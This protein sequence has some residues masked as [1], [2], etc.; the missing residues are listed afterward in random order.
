[1]IGNGKIRALNPPV[2]RINAA[3][4]IYNT[5]NN[6]IGS[7]TNRD[8]L[9]SFTIERVG[10]ESSFFG[11]GICQKLNVHL[12]SLDYKPTTDYYI[13][14]TVWDTENYS[15]IYPRFNI[16]EV[17]KNENNS[18]LSVTAYDAIYNAAEHTIE[19]L[20]TSV[21]SIREFAEVIASFLG[22]GGVELINITDSCFDTVY[23]ETALA[24]YEGTETLREV[25]DDIA[26]ATQTIYYVNYNNRLVFKRLDKDGAAALTIGKE[27]YITLD[28]GENRRLTKIVSAT[29]LGDDIEATLKGA[30]SG[31]LIRVDDVAENTHIVE[32]NTSAD[33]VFRYGKNIA[34]TI[35]AGK[36]IEINGMTFTGASDGAILVSGIP[37]AIAFVE[38]SAITAPTKEGFLTISLTGEFNNVVT[39]FKIKDKDGNL[40]KQVQTANRETINLSDYP[41]ATEWIVALKR[42]NNNVEASGAVYYQVEIGQSAT[43]YEKYKG[44]AF[45]ADNTGAFNVTSTAPTMT[46]CTNSAASELNIVYER[47]NTISGTT[48]YIRN[49]ALWDL[50]ED[51][52]SLIDKALAQVWGL[53]INQFECEWRGNYLL[54]IGDKIDL[55]AKDNN[56]VTS[57]V[58][59]DVI[60]YSGGFK[61]RTKWHYTESEETAANASNIG[62][63]LKQTYA[64]VDK[65]NKQIDIVA[66]QVDNNEKSIAQIYIDTESIR[67]SAKSTKEE[68]VNSIDNINANINTINTKVEAAITAEDVQLKIEQELSN[69]VDKVKTS[70][71]YTFNDDGLIVEKSD[72]EMK[73]TIS[74]DGMKVYRNSNE[75]L[76]AD[77][78]GVKAENLHATTYLILGNNSRFEDYGGRTG[79]FW[80]G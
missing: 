37:S 57:Y 14:P 80:I 23:S 24:N 33:T 64:R 55:V 51:R 42:L 3:V 66:S 5:D 62:E 79:C 28:S 61:E 32:V 47:A 65:V 30:A 72:S 12:T 50:R 49:N 11:F 75:V 60:E 26:E 70:T 67:A 35:E 74:D 48:Q 25:L 78:T 58:L 29:E 9:K 6:I 16:T 43:P 76:T 73:T 7:Y 19:E 21:T 59:N 54:E 68:L 56:I 10:E 17:H 45:T 69:G 77:N 46:I 13:K 27:D 20:V 18:E 38:L 31:A 53:T 40:L 41:T 52:A 2:R 4:N 71:G 44:E 8:K 36:T 34:P 22:C 39:D 63:L 15:E 1:M